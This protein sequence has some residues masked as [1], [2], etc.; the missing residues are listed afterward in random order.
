MKGLPEWKGPYF[1]KHSAVIGE[2]LCVCIIMVTQIWM[3]CHPFTSAVP[4]LTT[5][6]CLYL[7]TGRAFGS[8]IGTC[9]GTLLLSRS[10]CH[11]HVS[12]EWDL[13][14]SDHPSPTQP[15]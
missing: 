10:H 4:V 3:W 2:A 12:F 7:G 11:P 8:C 14:I 5:L 15:P 9:R 6:V 1:L 13:N